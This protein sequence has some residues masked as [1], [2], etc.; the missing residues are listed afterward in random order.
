[1]SGA[2]CIW[3]EAKFAARNSGGSAQRFCSKDC[4]Q[5]FY[6]ACRNWAV[7]QYE[8]DNVPMSEIRECLEQRARCVERDRANTSQPSRFSG[9]DAP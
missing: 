9:P 5:D 4:R 8:A 1:M 3:C 7:R 6:I 2:S